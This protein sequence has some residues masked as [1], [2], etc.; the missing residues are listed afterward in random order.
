[1]SQGHF[2]YLC[3]LVMLYVRWPVRVHLH[4][5][6]VFSRSVTCVYVCVKEHWVKVYVS[7]FVCVC[8]EAIRYE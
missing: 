1:M 5:C 7:V 2:V 3:G 6:H 8:W 4:M